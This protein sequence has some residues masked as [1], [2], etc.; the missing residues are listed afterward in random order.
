MKSDTRRSPP[1][2]P[3][4]HLSDGSKALWRALVPRRAK[5]PERMALLTTALESRDRAETASAIVARE[6]VVL[7]TQKT[8]MVHLNPVLR[9]ERDSR[10]LFVRCWQ[11]LGLEWGDDSE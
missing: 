11:A 2:D 6:G 5:S 1:R 8:G 7:T 3:P 4:A 9:L 10:Q